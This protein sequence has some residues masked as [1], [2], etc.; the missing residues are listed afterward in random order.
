MHSR[1]TGAKLAALQFRI[2]QKNTS[3]AF[4]LK[5]VAEEVRI[6]RSLARMSFGH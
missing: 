4:A 2:S 6:P 1:E 5:S 3:N